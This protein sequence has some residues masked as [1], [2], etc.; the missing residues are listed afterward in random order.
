MLVCGLCLV[1]ARTWSRFFKRASRCLDFIRS[2]PS[3]PAVKT[4]NRHCNRPFRFA[5]DIYDTLIASINNESATAN[6]LFHLND[7]AFRAQ[8]LAVCRARIR[9]RSTGGSRQ[10]M[11]QHFGM[12]V[13]DKIRH[14][15]WHPFGHSHGTLPDDLNLRSRD[16][17]V[18]AHGYRPVS[19]AAIAKIMARKNFLL[20]DSHRP[21]RDGPRPELLVRAKITH[22]QAASPA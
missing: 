13:W 2:Q 1:V 22:L 16:L 9:C 18:D 3:T 8:G 12:C 7:F 21:R 20:V 11:L 4:I 6:P 14:N 17:G 10:I 15:S 19:L 5:S